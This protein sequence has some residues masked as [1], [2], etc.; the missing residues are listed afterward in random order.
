MVD[1][2]QAEE[3]STFDHSTVYSEGLEAD[4]HDDLKRYCDYMHN[5]D[6]EEVITAIKDMA[7]HLQ[8]SRWLS[9]LV[10]Q[11]R[12]KIERMAYSRLDIGKI[13]CFKLTW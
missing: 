3:A 8:S 5:P 11:V 10:E 7:L 2:I 6:K 9:I 13:N 4:V 12:P 1:G